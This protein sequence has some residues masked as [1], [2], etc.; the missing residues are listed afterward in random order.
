MKYS[1]ESSALGYSP[2][3]SEDVK[4][5]FYILTSFNMWDKTRDW[6][7]QRSG[8]RKREVQVRNAFCEV[9][10][11]PTNSP[12]LVMALIN[13][14]VT[15]DRGPSTEMARTSLRWELGYG[16]ANVQVGKKS[17]PIHVQ[18][19]SKSWIQCINCLAF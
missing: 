4:P 16:E 2:T 15:N 3:F 1:S 11:K 14:T 18:G 19:G 8:A 9:Q 7:T 12:S 5:G 17:F 6:S 10:G 13:W